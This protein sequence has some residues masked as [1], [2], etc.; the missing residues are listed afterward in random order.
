M[1]HLRFKALG[2]LALAALFC[3]SSWASPDT[4]N[5]ANPSSVVPGTINYVEGEVFLGKQALNSKSV[6]TEMQ[7][8][9]SLTTENGMAEVLLTPGVFLR[10]GDNSDVNMISP[11]LAD[12]EVGVAKGEVMLE[13]TELHKQND[14]R[15]QEAG[16]PVQVLKTGLYD[17]DAN[18]SQAR[19]FKGEALVPVGDKE[20]KLKSDHEISLNAESKVKPQKFDEKA[21]EST[22]TLYRWSSL[23]SEYES[24]ANID[25]AQIYQ[26]YGWWGPG[27]YWDPWFGAYT[28]MPGDGIFCSPFGWG[29]YSPWLAYGAPIGFYGHY[30]HQFGPNVAAWGPGG[31][32]SAGIL[33]GGLHGAD[34]GFH[35]GFGG[36]YRGDVF[37]G[38]GF[39]NGF[40]AGGFHGGFGGGFAGGGFHR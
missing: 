37:A 11:G 33:G 9:E 2:G 27:W 38:G 30:Y 18:D 22:D 6:G 20:V 10:V 31:Y 15:V 16:I 19:V 13:V 8:G 4:P 35:S 1:K 40:G 5:I 26:N 17:F 7:S 25:A 3:T 23:R 32:Y 21:Y 34:R 14:L 24:E 29:F 39:H 28:F 36:F 12:T